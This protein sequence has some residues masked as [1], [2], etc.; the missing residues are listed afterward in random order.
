MLEGAEGFEGGCPEAHV[1]RFVFQC[2]AV[3]C[4]V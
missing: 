3:G 1:L 2:L 4:F